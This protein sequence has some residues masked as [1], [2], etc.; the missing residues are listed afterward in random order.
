MVDSVD[1]ALRHLRQD[2]T[3]RG[4]SVVDGMCRA[5]DQ[6]GHYW[7]FRGDKAFRYDAVRSAVVEP[8][9]LLVRHWPL[10]AGTEF[11][12]GIDA[13]YTTYH[14]PHGYHWFFTGGLAVQYDSVRGV[15]LQGPAAVD[16]IFRFTG[17]EADFARGIDAVCPPGPSDGVFWFFRGSR[18]LQY[19]TRSGSLLRPAGPLARYWPGLAG[20]VFAQGVD[21][22][23]TVSRAP[24]GRHWFVAGDQAVQYDSMRHA[25]RFGPEPL[26]GL[27]AARPEDLR[28]D[29]RPDQPCPGAPLRR[30]DGL[31]HT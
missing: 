9:D 29:R 10:L 22:C 26:A 19:D 1:S 30:L 8:A 13:C 6:D 14:R 5:A 28:P 27:I 23:Y 4:R 2:R 16:E 7:F 17:A 24:G 18:A 15:I 3:G 20:T 25:I 31:P 11:A 12:H 21:A